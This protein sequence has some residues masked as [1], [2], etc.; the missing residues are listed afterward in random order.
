MPSINT[1]TNATTMSKS[2]RITRSKKTTTA[3]VVSTSD[4]DMEVTFPVPV[5]SDKTPAGNSSAKRAA[6]SAPAPSR[7]RKRQRTETGLPGDK[8]HSSPTPGSRVAKAI[9]GNQLAPS[10]PRR[11]GR[12]RKNPIPSSPRVSTPTPEPEPQQ[13]SENGGESDSDSVEESSPAP[14]RLFS[15]AIRRGPKPGTKQVPTPEASS[16]ESSSE[17]SESEREDEEENSN[18][19]AVMGSLHTPP[20]SQP[21][22][23]KA[24]VLSSPAEG[25]LITHDLPPPVAKGVVSPLVSS[26]SSTAVSSPPF[27]NPGSSPQFLGYPWLKHLSGGVRVDGYKRVIRPE[28][29]HS[30]YKEQFPENYECAVK[31]EDFSREGCFIN[32]GHPSIDATDV[33][34]KE[35]TEA[36]AFISDKEGSPLVALMPGMLTKPSSIF[37]VDKISVAEGRPEGWTKQVCIAPL[38]T[39]LDPNIKVINDVYKFKNIVGGPCEKEGL[40]FQTM[41]GKPPAA[42]ET[43]TASSAPTSVTPPSDNPTTRNAKKKDNNLKANLLDFLDTNRSVSTSSG[44][45]YPYAASAEVKIPIYEGRA[46]EGYPFNFTPEDFKTLHKRPTVSEELGVGDYVVVGY[47]IATFGGGGA[48]PS[49]VGFNLQFV[50]LL[51]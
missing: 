51:I 34:T 26:S 32:L 4:V 47:T 31:I 15:V 50:I 24:V 27:T 39:C 14:C 12:P 8:D 48:F 40:I 9:K 42:G 17:S 5:K 20:H 33:F 19:D 3:A 16:N 11:R 23:K 13:D 49:M 22:K 45:S 41:R 29:M 18:N 38:T 28:N 36:K 25:V 43:N 2:G 21:S 7:I 6:P 37:K 10:A 44:T 35:I 1:N 46:S 30:A